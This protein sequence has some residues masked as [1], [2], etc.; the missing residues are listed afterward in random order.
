[1]PRNRIIYQNEGLFVGP[2]PTG[3]VGGVN[4]DIVGNL[5]HVQSINYDF[6][7]PRETANILG[8]ASSID[9]YVAGAP[10]VALTVNYAGNSF[11]NEELVGLNVSKNAAFIPVTSGVSLETTRQL[12]R[13]NMYLATAID[14]VDL[15]GVHINNV[16][17]LLSFNI[18]R[19]ESYSF[20]IGVGALA[21]TSMSFTADDAN[22]YI[23]GQSVDVPVLDRRTRNET[24]TFKI[25]L[26]TGSA[27]EVLMS[28]EGDITLPGNVSVSISDTNASTSFEDIKNDSVQSFSVDF[29]LPRSPINLVGYKMTWDKPIA[30]PTTA[31]CSM[32]MIATTGQINS[33]NNFIKDDP[34]Y[35][36]VLEI[37]QANDVKKMQF[38]L[39]NAVIDQIGYGAAVGDGKKMVNLDISTE[40]DPLSTDQGLFLSGKL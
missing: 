40:L 39:K 15:K 38:T 29:S 33:F 7:V 34:R 3:L 30:Y 2:S 10:A 21:Q 13:K 23:S 11:E 12:D 35:E 20:D 22:Y 31:S 26:P 14:G 28:S 4:Y 32:E 37:K 8:K 9:K 5:E 1:M 18:C 6:S 27:Q 24:D 19:L 25:T 17:G 36:V 16:S